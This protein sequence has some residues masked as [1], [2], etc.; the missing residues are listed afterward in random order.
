MLLITNKN[1]HNVHNFVDNYKN[2]CF[3]FKST[4]KPYKQGFYQ[5]VTIC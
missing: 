4:R 3:D 1:V 5:F 2:K